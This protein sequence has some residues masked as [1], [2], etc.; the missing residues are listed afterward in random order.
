[1]QETA[2]AGLPMLL[3]A[4]L[5]HAAP[6]CTPAEAVPE[7]LPPNF[8]ESALLVMRVLN[9]IARY[10]PW[11]GCCWIAIMRVLPVSFWILY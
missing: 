8:V 3:T 10:G 2:M 7:R 6:S 1:M 4:V 9:N 11:R 5:L